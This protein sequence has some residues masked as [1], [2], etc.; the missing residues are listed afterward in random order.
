MIGYQSQNRNDVASQVLMKNPYLKPMAYQAQS[1]S[2][3]INEWHTLRFLHEVNRL[4]GAI[5]GTERAGVDW[6]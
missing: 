4:L 3:T 6:H 5:D 1:E 2:I